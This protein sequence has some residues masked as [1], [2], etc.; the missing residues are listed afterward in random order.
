MRVLIVRKIRAQAMPD[1]RLLMVGSPVDGDY[2]R[3]LHRVAARDRDWIDFRED[4][5]R[6]ELNTLM[7]RCRYGIQAMEHEHFGMASAEMARAGCIVF[8][9]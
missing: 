4:L 2:T 5:P 8:K 9:P 6:A 3:R 7:G 1:A